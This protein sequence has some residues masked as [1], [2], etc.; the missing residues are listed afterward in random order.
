V[1]V[2]PDSRESRKSFI[3]KAQKNVFGWKYIG[4]DSRDS[5]GG[6]MN[7]IEKKKIAPQA[8][9]L[10]EEEVRELKPDISRKELCDMVNDYIYYQTDDLSEEEAH[11][12]VDVT[13]R[14]TSKERSRDRS[15][16]HST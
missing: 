7:R 6:V 2:L 9:K 3:V 8:A 5:G 12:I 16:R 1:K 13:C 14:L 15:R 4:A 10:F 11:A